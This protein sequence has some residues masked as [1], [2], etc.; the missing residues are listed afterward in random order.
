MDTVYIGIMLAAF[1]LCALYVRFA[2]R[3]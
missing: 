3:V 1:W 2:D